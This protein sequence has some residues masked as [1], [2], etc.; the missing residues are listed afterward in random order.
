MSVEAGQGSVG[1]ASPDD[2]RG[3]GWVLFSG[4]LLLTLGALNIIDGITAISRSHF[5]VANA[6]YVFGSLRTWGWV[7]LGLGVLQILIGLGVFAKNQAA[8]WAGVVILSLNAIAQLLMIPSYPFWSLAIFA[9]DIVAIYGL[10]AYGQ[11]LAD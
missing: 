5:F 8:R 2:E 4:V 3:M 6:H 1:Y 10:V 7:A 9:I 11:R